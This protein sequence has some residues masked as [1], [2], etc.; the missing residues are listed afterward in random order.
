MERSWV[1]STYERGIAA[2][3]PSSTLTGVANAAT[4]WGRRW[5]SA[6]ARCS[7]VQRL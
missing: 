1:V 3:A 4:A 6:H 7:S 5:G 2:S